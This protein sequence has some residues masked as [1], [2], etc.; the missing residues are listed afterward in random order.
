MYRALIKFCFILQKKKTKGYS[1]TSVR[2]KKK[3]NLK[4]N[5]LIF[6]IFGKYYKISKIEL[7]YLSKI[8]FLKNSLSFQNLL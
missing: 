1:P 8:K 4:K 6:K 2:F 3:C 5:G 7:F